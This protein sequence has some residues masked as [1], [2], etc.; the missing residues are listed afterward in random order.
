LQY[1]E[2][3]YEHSAFPNFTPCFQYTVLGSIPAV[4]LWL[5]APVFSFQLELISKQREL[6]PLPWTLLAYFKNVSLSNS[7]KDP[8]F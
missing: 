7:L 1:N 4:F 3:Y 2:S 5:L 6:L 8:R